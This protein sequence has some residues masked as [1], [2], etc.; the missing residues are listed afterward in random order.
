MNNGL[1]FWFFI[2]CKNSTYIL[3]W[4][5]LH[6]YICNHFP[7]HSI[8]LEKRVAVKLCYA[9]LQYAVAEPKPVY[10]YSQG[11]LTCSAHY[12]AGLFLPLPPE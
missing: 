11:L 2:E 8:V 10:N 12:G 4:N 5:L 3:K 6:L 9:A 1:K 7:P